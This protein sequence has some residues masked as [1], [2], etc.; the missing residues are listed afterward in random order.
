MAFLQI[1]KDDVTLSNLVSLL[2]IKNIGVI[3][4]SYF[5]IVV[6]YDYHLLIHYKSVTFN[7]L[8]DYHFLAYLQSYFLLALYKIF[9]FKYNK[10]KQLL[11]RYKVTPTSIIQKYIF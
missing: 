2:L 11:I 4:N 5:I 6:L 9:I 1:F 10:R 3:F 7:T 8:Q